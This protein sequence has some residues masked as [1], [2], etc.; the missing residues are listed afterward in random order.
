MIEQSEHSPSAWNVCAAKWLH[1]NVWLL[2]PRF[3]IVLSLV[4]AAI[5]LRG[6]YD[7]S[8]GMEDSAWL[9]L[10][11]FSAGLPSL[12]LVAGWLGLIASQAWQARRSSDRWVAWAA[13]SFL[14]AIALQ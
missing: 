11:F 10:A 7:V 12:V 14:L 3:V 5:L 9:E 1:T 13:A 2:A 8:Q 6:I 4:H